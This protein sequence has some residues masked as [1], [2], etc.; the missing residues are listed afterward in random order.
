MHWKYMKYDLY[1]SM[2]YM[3]YIHMHTYTCVYTCVYSHGSEGKHSSY[4]HN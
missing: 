1:I 4:M 3:K 2:K